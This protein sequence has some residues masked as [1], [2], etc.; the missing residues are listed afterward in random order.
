M[1]QT[2]GRSARSGIFLVFLVLGLFTSANLQAQCADTSPTGDCDGDGIVNSIDQ[3]DDNDGIP[4][5]AEYLCPPI[6]SQL[7]WGVPTWTGGNPDDDFSS[8]ATT[9]I[10]GIQIVADNTLTALAANRT[11]YL[12]QRTTFHGTPVL[13]I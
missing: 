7:V 9:T 8:T 3:D 5:V 2:L 11:A 1:E 4:D 13:R 10:D 6:D 12:T